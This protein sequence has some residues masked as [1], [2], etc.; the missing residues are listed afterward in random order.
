MQIL[1]RVRKRLLQPRKTN[2]PSR[3]KRLSLLKRSGNSRQNVFIRTD[4][5]EADSGRKETKGFAEILII[6]CGSCKRW[7]VDRNSSPQEVATDGPAGAQIGPAAVSFSP[8]P[9][10]A[11]Y[12]GTA[13]F[14][15][16]GFPAGCRPFSGAGLPHR[17]YGRSRGAGRMAGPFPTGTL[18][19][20][21]DKPKP[22]CR[23]AAGLWTGR[24]LFGISPTRGRGSR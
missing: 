2:G 3:K 18:L 20:A 17:G 9:A 12:G 1:F 4:T 22:G 5:G 10:A 11:G 15:Y 19:P 14:R 16:T 24:L 8:A 7:L 6:F 21:H 23:H 13:A